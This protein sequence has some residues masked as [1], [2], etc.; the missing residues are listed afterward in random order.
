MLGTSCVEARTQRFMIKLN[1]DWEIVRIP[2][3]A[4]GN[5]NHDADEET[6]WRVQ[7]VGSECCHRAKAGNLCMFWLAETRL[8]STVT[9]PINR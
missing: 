1:E 8:W 6:Y 4:N 5:R 2:L 7:T 3:D 9:I